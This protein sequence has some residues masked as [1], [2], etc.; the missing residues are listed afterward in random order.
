MKIIS[1]DIGKSNVVELTP[2]EV[3]FR[4]WFDWLTEEKGM[5]GNMAFAIVLSA[6]P[7]V[8]VDFLAWLGVGRTTINPIITPVAGEPVPTIECRVQE[9]ENCPWP[10]ECV[11]RCHYMNGPTDMVLIEEGD[12]YTA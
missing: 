12:D 2:L 5:S 3:T 11:C 6:N 4:Q 7:P 8:G 9:H 10:R 1:G